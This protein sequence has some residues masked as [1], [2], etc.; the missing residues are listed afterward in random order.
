MRCPF[1]HHPDTQVAETRVS[2]DGAVVRRRR[3]CANCE[4]RFTTYERAEVNMPL[5]IKKNGNR[6]EYNPEKLRSSISLALRKRPVSIEAIDLAIHHI[7][8]ML[9]S[10]GLKEITSGTIGEYVM[11][12]LAQLDKVA[13]VRFASVYHSFENVDEFN[14]IIRK[15]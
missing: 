8:Q 15:I 11:A 14:K 1:C 3:R 7:E 6:V 9:L 10:S 13:Y 5:V 4:Q 2:D 12:E